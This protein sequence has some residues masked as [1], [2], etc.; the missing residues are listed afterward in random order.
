MREERVPE[1][2]EERLCGGV[3][4]CV[5]PSHRFGTDAVLLSDFALPEGARKL[6]LACDLGSGCG[7]IPMLWYGRGCAPERVYAV[8]I[9]PEGAE[10][11]RLGAEKNGLEGRFFPICADMTG[12]GSEQLPL[13]RFDL[14]TC[15]P[16][17]KAEG[18]GIVSRSAADITARHEG[19]C[20]IDSVCRTASRLLRFGGSFCMCFRP[21]R[22]A[23]AICA[24]RANK[25]EPKRLRFVCQRDGLEPWLFLMEAR[26]G[27]GAGLR[28]MPQLVIER[29]GE[30]TDELK[31]IYEGFC[32]G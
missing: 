12:L 26:R 15:N 18:T 24:A 14:V 1:Y 20:S 19:G 7:I 13:G 4:V 11:M 10:L 25:L 32:R 16:P 29:G 9:Q 28:V 27:G 23:D 31:K 22:L 6:R 17:Y 3:T 30:Y 21:E 8:E 2:S 5:S